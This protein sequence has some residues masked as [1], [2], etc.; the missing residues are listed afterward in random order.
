METSEVKFIRLPNGSTLEVS[1]YPGFL[2]KVMNHFC[3][4]STSTVNDEHIRMYIYYAFKGAID[5]QEN[6]TI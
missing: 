3:L 2:Q 1:I 4:D 5:R 6:G